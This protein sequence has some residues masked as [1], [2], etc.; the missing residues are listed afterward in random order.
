[1]ARDLDLDVLADF[2]EKD[3]N[4]NK[5]KLNIEDF[6]IEH[7][8][9][10]S[11]LII[12]EKNGKIIGRFPYRP[13]KIRV[14]ELYDRI[15]K[16]KVFL[17]EHITMDYPNLEPEYRKR[18]LGEQAYKKVEEITGKKILPDTI[19]TAH[20]STLHEKKGL[21]KSFGKKEYGPGII[22]Q[23]VEQLKKLGIDDPE[24]T[25]K[26]SKSAFKQL[27]ESIIDMGVTDFKSIAPILGKVGAAAAGGLASA[28]AEAAVE[29]MEPTSSGATPNMPD[30]WLEKG[31]RDPKEQDRLAKLIGFKQGLTTGIN[32]NKIPGPYE[33]PESKKYKES[34]LEA[35]KAGTLLP[36][37]VEQNPQED[38]DMVQKSQLE[39][40]RRLRNT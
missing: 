36:N 3:L 24:V 29:A 8:P 38:M 10:H 35:E 40:L 23:V 9:A 15:R 22:Q 2:L 33:K 6:D 4:S 20:S 17:P 13:S 27:Q 28:G 30:Y 19:L 31:I 16:E 1:M 32:Y 26:L 21:G 39:A 5:S 18:G 11:Q 37:Y 25:E 7:S 34:V 14:P 12:K